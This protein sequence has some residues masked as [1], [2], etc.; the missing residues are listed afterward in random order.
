[1]LTMPF[2]GA[3]SLRRPLTLLGTLLAVAMALSRGREGGDSLHFS[4]REEMKKRMTT[5]R[6]LLLLSQATKTMKTRRRRRTAYKRVTLSLSVS[7]H[8]VF[9]QWH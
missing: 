1:M 8:V 3:D 5:Q 6:V 7:S 4:S 2:N 9:V